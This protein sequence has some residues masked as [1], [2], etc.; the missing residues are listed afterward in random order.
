MER[1]KEGN[2]EKESGRERD[3]DGTEWVCCRGSEKYL[4][5]SRAPPSIA[6]NY[7]QKEI[8]PGLMSPAQSSAQRCCVRN[9]QFVTGRRMFVQTIGFVGCLQE[10]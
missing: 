10:K 6:P 4:M 8:I 2:R 9:C 3:R 7:K 1:D 5:L